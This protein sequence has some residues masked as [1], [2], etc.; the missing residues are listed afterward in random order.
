MSIKL[1]GKARAMR[2]EGSEGFCKMYSRQLKDYTDKVRTK[3][4]KP[5]DF[6]TFNALIAHL[7]YRSRRCNIRPAR[8]AEYL[9][10]T[11]ANTNNSLKRLRTAGMICK[12]VKPDGGIYFMTDPYVAQTGRWSNRERRFA[13]WEKTRQSDTACPSLEEAIPA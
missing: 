4:L 10:W 12:A 6:C 1:E 2:E 7:D 3:E 8:L 13:I 5:A 9:G 11:L